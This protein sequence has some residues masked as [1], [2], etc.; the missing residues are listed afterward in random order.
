[1]KLFLLR[2]GTRPYTHGDVPL[3]EQGKEE[4][5]ALASHEALQ[6]VEKIISSPKK[7]AIMTVEP[8]AHRLGLPIEIHGD[9]DQMNRLESQGDFKSRI[10][11]F[12]EF[13]E[14]Q[15]Q[16]TLVCSHSDWLTLATH[17]LPSDSLEVQDHLFQCA[18][19]ISFRQDG[20][21]WKHLN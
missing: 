15:N 14:S 12:L 2:H 18:E 8:L 19:F 6:G 20:G 3:N 10:T 21:L 4:A 17:L 16:N 9:L 5:N 11:R 7:R 13:L 1:M